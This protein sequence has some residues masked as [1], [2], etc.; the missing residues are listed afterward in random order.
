MSDAHDP[1]PA[2]RRNPLIWIALVVIGIIVYVVAGGD[3]RGPNAPLAVDD[4]P[5]E[6]AVIDNAAST[7]NSE[8]GSNNLLASLETVPD[9]GAAPELD[10]L[11]ESELN[12]GTIQRSLLVPPGMRAREYIRQLR[13]AGEPYPLSEVYEKA[14]GYRD[15]GSLADAHLLYFFAARE[16][17]LPAMM[18]M[19]EMADPGWFRADESLLDQADPVQAYKWYRKAADL[20]QAEALARLETLHGWAQDAAAAGD[21]EARQLLLNYQ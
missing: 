8:T 1:A 17:H 15:E 2:P 5:A 7:G 21:L 6:S 13:E 12:E 9:T 3:R 16:S 4:S 14:Q 10:S 20:G 11:A 18:T 19:A